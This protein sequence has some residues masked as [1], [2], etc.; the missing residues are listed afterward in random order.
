MIVD[1]V[2]YT[3]IRMLTELVAGD[4]KY[5]WGVFMNMLIKNG[6]CVGTQCLKQS[7]LGLGSFY[8]GKYNPV[9][10]LIGILQ[11]IVHLTWSKF[12]KKNEES[13]SQI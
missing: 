10:Y 7:V 12:H 11:V 1:L 13:K 9:V 6:R 2:L 3:A 4:E 8:K 5:I